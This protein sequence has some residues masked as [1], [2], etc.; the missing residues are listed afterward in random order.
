MHALDNLVAGKCVEAAAQ[1][2]Q[3]GEERPFGDV[4]ELD[5]FRPRQNTKEL[6]ALAPEK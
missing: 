5:T 3:N 1:S 6:G 4:M 2:Y